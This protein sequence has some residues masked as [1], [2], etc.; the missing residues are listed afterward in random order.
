MTE[1]KMW[2]EIEKAWLEAIEVLKAGIGVAA[3]N[4]DYKQLVHLTM[5][6]QQCYLAMN[7]DKPD[8][9]GIDLS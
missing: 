4:A 3:E 1:E 8:F 6:V 2:E 5:A 7:G 9:N